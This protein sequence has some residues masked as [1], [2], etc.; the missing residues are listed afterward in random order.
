MR[1]GEVVFT[2]VRLRAQFP[3]RRL[4]EEVLVMELVSI[5]NAAKLLQV[6]PNTLRRNESPDGKWC[7]IYG[8]RLRI[9]K[10][11]N[12]PGAQRRYDRDEI[13]RLLHRLRR[14]A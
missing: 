8:A 6:H 10:V 12:E 1:H 7:L 2:L 3:L 11:S 13:E 14:D 5:Q 9:Y 4:A